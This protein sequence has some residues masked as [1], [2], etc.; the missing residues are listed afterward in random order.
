VS[1]RVVVVGGSLGGLTA[2]LWLRELGYDVD[3]Y[4][5]ARSALEARGAGI[6]LN[7]ATVRYLVVEDV[8]EIE[9]I[10]A[11]AHRLRYLARDGGLA[12]E[13]PCSYMFTSYD[14]LYRGL[15]GC[16]ER[17]RYHLGRECVGSE[18]AGDAVAARFADGSVE[19]CELLV[20]ADGV[21]STGRRL[22]L[23]GVEPR[24]A[25]Y[26][27]WRGTVSEAEL[28][29]E[30][31]AAMREAIAYHVGADGHALAYP[32]P[33]H[34]GSVEPGHRLTNWLW[35]R[36][37]PEGPELDDLLTGKDGV[38][39]AGS[40]PPDLVRADKRERLREDAAA[41]LPPAFAEMIAASEAPFI[42]VVFDM[43]APRMAFGRACLIGDAALT[44][45]PHVAA[46]TAKAAEDAW[47]LAEALRRAG[48][49]VAGALAEWEPAQLE[50]GR[51]LASTAR[52]AGA[53]LQGGTWDVGDPLPFGLY[54]AGDSAMSGRPTYR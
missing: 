45:R 16:F 28:T 53:R 49:D 42:Q 54:E 24:Y 40:L 33:D 36:N 38:R 19:R 21:G 8:L 32:I 30:T 47:K 39:L 4:E 10:S 9:A 35:Y 20:Y 25:G 18:Q 34:E 17:G 5:R 51:R 22:L 26:I 7:P 15:L 46:G 23:P 43:Q 2:A 3:V 52:A 6:V 12:A 27:A 44:L 41:I 31:F 13:A 48:G 50:L 1:G 37:V 14:S 29:G 11:S